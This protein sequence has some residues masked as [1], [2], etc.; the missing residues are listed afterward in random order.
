MPIRTAF[1]YILAQTLGSFTGAALISFLTPLDYDRQTETGVGFP[2]MGSE[3]NESVG[4]FVEFLATAIYMYM[5]MCFSQ[6]HRLP[7]QVYGIACG[8]ACMLGILTAGP[9]TGG[10]MNPARIVGP[11]IV[12]L[13]ESKSHPDIYQQLNTYWF[14]FLGPIFG[15]ILTSFYYEFFMFDSEDDAPEIEHA[16]YDPT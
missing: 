3:Y 12:S 11:M 15:A 10:C 13:Y 5:V 6:D 9:I 1:Y 2:K 16:G 4:F 8:L 7:K 14:Y